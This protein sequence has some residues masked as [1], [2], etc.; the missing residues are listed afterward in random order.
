MLATPSQLITD[1]T[2]D[3]DELAIEQRIL[4][5]MHDYLGISFIESAE[6]KVRNQIAKASALDTPF[7]RERIEKA[8]RDYREIREQAE[9]QER[10]R[11]VDGNS[12]PDAFDVPLELL[13]LKSDNSLSASLSSISHDTNGHAPRTTPKQRR[14]INPPPPSTSTYYYYQAA[15]GLP[16]YLHPVDIRILLSHFGEYASFPDSITVRVDAFSE[17]SVNDELRKRCKYLAHLPESTNVIFVEADLE[18]VVGPEGLKNFEG[19][20]KMR[21]SRRREK[22]RKDERAKARAEER[23][24]EKKQHAAQ[25]SWESPDPV[26]IPA[27]LAVIEH[28]VEEA[29]TPLLQQTSGAW[30]QGSFASALRSEPSRGNANVPTRAPRDMEDEWDMDIA[31]H[32]LEQRSSGTGKKKR[33]KGLVVLGGGGGR[34][35]R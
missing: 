7:L 34:R 24:R 27:S 28:D 8:H 2:H 9:L 31:W 20:L 3:L 22:G 23:E 30:G 35:G 14:N 6:H 18:G 15:S 11:K 17:G 12:K 4:A 25:V 29:P 10:R 33:N 16:L 5:G 13:A 19:A 1:L 21:K 32:E 26:R